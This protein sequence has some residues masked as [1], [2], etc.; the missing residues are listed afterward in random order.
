MKNLITTLGLCLLV[1]GLS[2][3]ESQELSKAEQR[4]LEKEQKKAEQRAE[5]L[6][7]LEQI[8]I[9]VERKKF[10][11]EAEY[12]SNSQGARFPVSAL[13]NYIA[14]D[15]TY[16]NFSA[17]EASRFGYQGAWLWA[18][19]API[20]S[21]KYRAIGRKKESY[22]IVINLQGIEGL[23]VATITIDANGSADADIRGKWG[24]QVGLH[25]R[26]VP[27]DRSTVFRESFGY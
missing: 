15:S 9:M 16:G 19:E 8:R 14:I 17:P 24:L 27:L 26:A 21:Y 3:Q 13:T 4:R 11:L 10:V 23:I 5:T 20:T 25:G 22:G 7:N 6:R 18:R 2:A 1:L 12:L